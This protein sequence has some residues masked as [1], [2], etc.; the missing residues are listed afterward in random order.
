MKKLLLSGLLA[1]GTLSFA[2]VGV[3]TTNPQ[4]MLDIRSSNPA[5]PST[6]DG[7]LIPKIHQFPNPNPGEDQQ[8]MLVYLT[9]AQGPQLPGFYYWDY[10]TTTWIPIR[11]ASTTGTLDDAYNFGSSGGGRTITA[12]AGAVTINGTDGLVVTG[13]QNN[14][15]FA[16]E[17]GGVRMVWNP[18]KNAFRAGSVEGNQWNDINIGVHSTAFGF[19][20]IASG[21]SS[22]SFGRNTNASGIRATAFGRGTAA[23]GEESTAFGLSAQAQGLRSLAFGTASVANGNNAVAFGHFTQALANEATAFGVNSVATGF[24]S[25]AFGVHP[26]ARSFGEIALGSYPTDYTP[27]NNNTFN[28]EDRL[29]VIGNGTSNAL[30]RDALTIRKDGLTTL[31]ATTNALIDAEPTGKVVVTKEWF[32]TNRGVTLNQAYNQGGSGIGR[33]ITADAGAV[34]INGTD[35]FVVTGTEGSGAIV[36]E[37]GGVRMVWNPRKNAF[38]AGTV[39]STQWNDFNIG[40]HS[41]A[42]GVNSLATGESAFCF[43]RNSNASGIRATAFGFQATASG[44]NATAFGVNTWATANNATAFGAST[45]ATA[46]EATAFGLF[47]EATGLYSTAFGLHAYARSFAE[48]AVGIYPTEYTPVNNNTINSSD[49]L[50][51]I[52]NGTATTSRSDALLVRKDGL[53]TLP[54]TTIALIDADPTGKAVVTKEWATANLGVTLN[55]AYN[56]GGNGSGRVITA[57]AGAVDIQGAGGL[58]VSGRVGLNVPSPETRLDVSPSVQ[59]RQNEG[60][61]V[62]GELTTGTTDTTVS[63]EQA[64]SNASWPFTGTVTPEWQSFTA[65]ESLE[66]FSIAIHIGSATAANTRTITVYQGEGTG[67]TVLGTTTIAPLHNVSSWV[68]SPMLNIPLQAG[69]VYT[70]HINDRHWWS[71]QMSDVYAGGRALHNVNHDFTFRITKRLDNVATT[72]F[73]VIGAANTPLTFN[74]PVA[75]SR[76]HL[77]GRMGI[78]TTTPRAPL[79]VEGLSDNTNQVNIRYFNQ[80]T[81]LLTVNNWSGN[82]VAYF[83]GNVIAQEAFIAT[84]NAVFSD[85]RIKTIQ[86]VSN[87][88]RDLE[89]LNRIQITDYTMKD[90]LRDPK[91]Y[92]KVIAQ[93]VEAHF[94]QAITRHKEFI[95]SVY[96]Q[97]TQAEPHPQGLLLQLPKAHELVVGD[98]VRLISDTHGE[99]DV[100]VTALPSPTQLVVSTDTP[101]EGRW[102]VFG[103]QVEDF[104]AVDYD[105]LAML[106]VS[107]TQEL[108]KRLEETQNQLKQLLEDHQQ[109]KSELEQVKTTQRYRVG[110]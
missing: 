50:F 88:A 102:F 107:A 65:T 68:E 101:T 100:P 32:I 63:M 97:A 11:G 24:Y 52:G 61:T 104:R 57:D 51:V 66:S 71:Y 9:T 75:N 85:E 79:H 47:S 20:S 28:P 81:N 45:R 34:T 16:P 108:L 96:C 17:G 44:M 18:R 7:L 14:G 35:G 8:G 70:I 106:N 37:G 86:G 109:L 12:T 25:T 10:T 95:P 26:I 46:N 2:Q 19:N 49:R 76:I 48:L 69:T 105:A 59:I 73:R 78:G 5:A 53:T 27:V 23:S 89:V 77:S 38:R 41:T 91:S 4:A 33:T 83:A 30:R 74:L 40:L 87:S 98:R 72:P 29:F 60:T 15:A 42:F 43:G 58:R 110:F 36:P 92:K 39:G 1:I 62:L 103:K 90:S 56:Q 64:I 22:F 55:Q 99:I 13:T 84:Q 94:P 6:T 82:T 93:Q 80:V 21:E 54:S 67:G 31:P 3:N